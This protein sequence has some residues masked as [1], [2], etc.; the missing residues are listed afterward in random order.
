MK[1]PRYLIKGDTIAIVATAR[2]HIEN[3]LEEAISFLQGLGINTIIGSSIGLENN[4]L[5]GS[6]EDRAHD[7]QTQ[8]NNPDV[9]AVWCVR[10]GYGTVRM[11]DLVDFS[12]F[13]E[14]PKWIIGFSDVTVL[15]Q[16]INNLGFAT[17]HAMMPVN[18]PKATQ[19]AKKTFAK[20]LFGETLT[21][22]VK[23]HLNN[24]SGKAS[25]EIVGGNLSI[26]YSLLGSKSLVDFEGKILFVEDL[27]EYFYHL[28]RMFVAL[29]RAGV[30]SG[31]Q[32]LVVGSMTS[33]HDNAIPWGKSAL[34][35]INDRVSKYSFP[36]VFD[37]PAGHIHNNCAL[38]LGKIATLVVNF[39]SVNL[40]FIP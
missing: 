20:A 13:H 16:H 34:E 37:F 35:I 32:G 33:M 10:G 23:P 6:D 12:N 15:H 7:F 19:E 29:D 17:L 27:D 40:E 31:L 36:V 28:D 39:D 22:S 14:D 18:L 25:A 21:Y 5:A 4:Q 9:R 38:P 2:K 26:L 30:L 8:L 1:T 11:V 24:R 3:Q